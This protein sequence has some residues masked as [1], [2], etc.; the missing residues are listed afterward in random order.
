MGLRWVGKVV[1]IG[2]LFRCVLASSCE[3]CELMVGTLK[4]FTN[5]ASCSGIPIPVLVSGELYSHRILNSTDDRLTP[6]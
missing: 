6:R 4:F 3:R 5:T 2:M 1:G